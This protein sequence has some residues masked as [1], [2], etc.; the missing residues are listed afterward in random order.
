[1]VLS[2]P[3]PPNFFKCPPLTPAQIDQYLSQAVDNTHELIDKTIIHGGRV[4][5]KMLSD[6]KHLKIYKG[7]YPG[8]P[9]NATIHLGYMEVMASLDE[10]IA[11]FDTEATRPK[12]FCRRFGKGL[13]DAVHLYTLDVPT[14]DAPY[15][16]TTLTWRAYDSQMPKMIMRRD[17]CQI[18]CHNSFTVEGRRGWVRSHKSIRLECCPN[19]ES[20][21]QL[22]RSKN[23]GSGHVFL[24]S[25]RPG[26][27][28]MFYVTHVDCCEGPSEWFVD[29]VMRCR[30]IVL[31]A[32]FKKRCRALLD[33]DVFLRED[34][35]SRMPYVPPRAN[36]TA[37]HRKC[38]L[39]CKSL[40]IIRKRQFCEKCG[41]AFCSRCV[42]VW[43]VRVHGRHERVLACYTCSIQ[44]PETRLRTPSLLFARYKTAVSRSTIPSENETR[45]TSSSTDS[46]VN[47]FLVSLGLSRATLARQRLQEDEDDDDDNDSLVLIE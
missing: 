3:L 4:S 42:N 30:R 36:S 34:R 21:C 37:L 20:V 5:Y 44:T 24:E 47:S 35:L 11:L 9:P 23:H 1:M 19:L 17:A 40:P 28:D 38:S 29:K 45:S 25:E 26:Y 12:E 2:L 6:E 16:K 14:V 33:I 8:A 27:L 31:D 7:D 43:D 32:I 15:K 41:E 22:I 18:E 13:L 46:K 10:V 39:C